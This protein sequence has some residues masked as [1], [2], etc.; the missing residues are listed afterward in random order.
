MS[1]HEK[2]MHKLTVDRLQTS[3]NIPA[4][5]KQTKRLYPSL[6]TTDRYLDYV[7]EEKFHPAAAERLENLQGDTQ[8]NV[9]AASSEVR[10]KAQILILEEQRQELLSINEK[11]A[12]EYHTMKQYYKDRVKTLLQ[13]NLFKEEM[14]DGE[15]KITLCRRVKDTDFSWIGD[16]SSEMLKAERE[17]KQLRTENSTLTRRVQHQHEE[18]ARLN[19]A[20][21]EALQAAPTPDASSET[22]FEVWKLQAETYKEDFRRERKDREKLKEKYLELEK[23]YRKVHSE[24]HVLKPQ[25]PRT[26]PPQPAPKCTCTNRAKSPNWDVHQINQHHTHSQRRNTP[27]NEP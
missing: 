19:K 25:A 26:Q 2:T 15:K 6:P 9:S 1:A 3:E 27:D 13:Q 7:S 10:L 14:D 22:L 5:R 20:L 18:I 21:E 24:L 12:K 11:W 17:A 23:K 8:S 16:S 4:E